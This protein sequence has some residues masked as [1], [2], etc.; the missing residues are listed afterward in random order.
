MYYA[1]RQQMFNVVVRGD[2]FLEREQ[3]KQMMVLVL[4]FHSSPVSCELQVA[5][6]PTNETTNKRIIIYPHQ[7]GLPS[8][9]MPAPQLDTD[10]SPDRSFFVCVPPCGLRT[11]TP[12]QRR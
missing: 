3:N 9:G 2:R 11:K 5:S 7:T 10:L 6:K 4:R 12:T 8:L 1:Y